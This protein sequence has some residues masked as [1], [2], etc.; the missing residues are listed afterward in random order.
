MLPV[1]RMGELLSMTHRLT[2]GLSG[3]AIILIVLVTLGG[4]GR[5]DP[6]N[7]VNIAG[8][9]SVQPLSE[10]LAN[11]FME[12]NP[13]ISIN[14]AGGGSSAGIKAASDGT[15]DIG[16]SSREL[17]RDEEKG[18]V[19]IP[20]AIDGIAVV[21]NPENP[22]KN[23][24]L[25]QIRRIYAE[26][27]TNWKQ[28]GGKDGAINAFTREEGSGTRGAFEDLVMEDSQ[29]S[30]SVGVQNA[31]GSLRTAVAG[32][33]HAIAYISLGNV[34][35]T[36]KVVAVE[37]VRPGR[38]SIKKGSY[39]LARSFFYLTGEQPRKISKQ[40]IDFVLSPEGQQIVGQG[41]VPVE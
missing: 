27:I 9:S 20:I 19:L 1:N 18:L 32:D 12:R 36:V 25:E 26:E 15:A 35:D 2:C 38:E 8:S 14:V 13:E 16:A 22:V 5:P 33:I 39:K 40:F 41:F 21:I 4:C 37:G 29:I 17:S 7:T 24:T 11:A 6:V 23:L 34:N 3:L 31:T 30:S 28:V 10:E